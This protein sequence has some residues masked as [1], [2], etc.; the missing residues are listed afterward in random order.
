MKRGNQTWELYNLSQDPTEL[1]DLSLAYP[2]KASS[3]E[4]RWQ[5]WADSV[6]VMERSK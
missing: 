4:M 5:S 6:G 2:D 3:L 1:N